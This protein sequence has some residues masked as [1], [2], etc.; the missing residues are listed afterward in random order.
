MRISIVS[1]QVNP[2]A[3]PGEQGWSVPAVHVGEL[4]DAL[5]ADGHEVTVLA[6]RD[7]PGRPATAELRPGVTVRHLDAGPPAPI[8]EERLV[9]A[10]PE[11]AT[12]LQEL[13][14][15]DPPEL[16]HAHQWTSG[17]AAGAAARDLGIPVVQTFHSLA[18]G[19]SD[20][21]PAGRA[22]AEQAVARSAERVLATSEDEAFALL[23][24]GA[25]RSRLRVVP[26]GIDTR[27]W[28]PDGPSLRRPER[29]RLV[30]LGTLAAGGGVDETIEALRAVPDAELFVAGGPSPDRAQDDPDLARLHGV[31]ARAGVARR[32]R[33]LG[34]VRRDDV[35][36]LLRS[37][38]MLVSAP[39]RE[40]SGRAAL[41]AMACARAVVATE[42]G[43]LRDTVVDQVTGVQVLP[44]RPAELAVA[45]RSVLAEPGTSTAFGIAGRDRATSRFVRSR[46]VD[47]LT[48]VY[49]EAVEERA[50]A[51]AEGGGR[52]AARSSG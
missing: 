39:L 49:R 31:A 38:D 45:V 22:S 11:L 35:P 3:E 37:A 29:P 40:S 1:V 23:Q 43:A 26:A 13:W 25:P 10:V 24:R 8:P 5:A 36:R 46:I 2:L 51:A 14:R 44:G 52:D 16:V 20:A 42:V 34:A 18:G 17:L 32:V 48:G 47:A 41:E 50:V 9:G 4:A 27:A 6:R 15:D 21:G 7:D 19:G 30:T 12:R 28:H 33:F